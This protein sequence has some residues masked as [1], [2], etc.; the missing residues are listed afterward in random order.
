M[1]GL[2]ADSIRTTSL[3]RN[4]PQKPRRSH[5]LFAQRLLRAAHLASMYHQVHVKRVAEVLAT[6]STKRCL[7]LLVAILA[8]ERDRPDR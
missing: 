7:K 8:L 3:R 4:C 6:K 2:S 5:C 1:R